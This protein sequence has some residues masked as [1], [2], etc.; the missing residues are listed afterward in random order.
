[1]FLTDLYT[2]LT[3]DLKA[4]WMELAGDSRPASAWNS[5]AYKVR[6]SFEFTSGKLSGLLNLESLAGVYFWPVLRSLRSLGY[7]N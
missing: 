2:K 6:L 1:M 7:T 5:Q 3:P 4:H